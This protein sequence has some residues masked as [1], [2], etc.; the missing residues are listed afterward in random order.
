MSSNDSHYSATLSCMLGCF[1][2]FHKHCRQ[3][4]VRVFPEINTHY[5][6]RHFILLTFLAFRRSRSTSAPLP[7]LY[8]SPTGHSCTR[9]RRSRSP[10]GGRRFAL[11]GGTQFF[12]SSPSLLYKKNDTFSPGSQTWRPKTFAGLQGFLSPLS[13]FSW[14]QAGWLWVGRRWGTGTSAL[15]V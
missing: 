9:S 12:C 8:C 3:L 1:Y 2:S 11:L 4:F 7:L 14:P 10:S 6:E 13:V 15:Q 5:W